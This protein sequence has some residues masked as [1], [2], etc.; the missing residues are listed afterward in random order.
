MY[1]LVGCLLERAAEIIVEH[2]DRKKYW[3]VDQSKKSKEGQDDD[4]D[5]SFSLGEADDNANDS[6][7]W[8]KACVRHRLVKFRQSA[9][10]SV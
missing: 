8:K 1:T 4:D 6:T 2:K 3:S 7:N 10:R 9:S 5:V